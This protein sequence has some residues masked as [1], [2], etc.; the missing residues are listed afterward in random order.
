T[1]DEHPTT[2]DA[3]ADEP[4]GGVP[5]ARDV[6]P[7]APGGG[8]GANYGPPPAPV[9]PPGLPPVVDGG[10][11]AGTVAPLAPVRPVPKRRSRVRWVVWAVV[12]VLVLAGVISSQINLDYYAIQPGTAQSVQPFITVPPGKAHR[13][14]KPV[15]LTDVRE[16]RVTALTYL[17]FKLQSNTS[18][19]PL[20]DVTGGTAP[21]ELNA[22][23][24]LQMSQAEASAKTAAL[25]HLGY[26]VTA[27][28]VG[29]VIAGTF[30]GTPAYGVLN[31]GD[32]VTA[33]DG[34]PTP[35]ALALTQALAPH[36]SGQTVT[37]T[38]RKG[39]TAAPG[40]VPLTL[41]RTTVQIGG[42]T[43]TLDVGIMPQDQV[44]YTYPFPISIAVTNIGGPS[45]GLAM[46]LGVIDTLSG[47]RLT[48]G[49]TV[50]ATGTMDPDG[51]VGDV[52]GVAQKTV[53]VEDAGATIFLVPPGEYADA[54]SK[55]RP[56]LKIYP[57]STLDQAL[58]VLA[59]NGG[60]VP[61][62]ALVAATSDAAG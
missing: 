37:F 13:V 16:A 54:R 52:G 55:L 42:R 7:P 18:L 38:V 50:A 28:P 32:V 60:H 57:V 33:L 4:G 26:P 44:A 6:V 49:H 47:G 27:T 20:P 58:R 25:R 61:T 39:G 51:Q 3:P 40:P 46:T 36:H 1:D 8:I 17:I 14:A 29:A 48:G 30:E 2:P 15:L 43:A 62:A 35:T 19:Y 34:K 53:A 45:A 23:G 12:G 5:P 21:S 56:G 59:A 31:V 24:D 41:K 10:F 22:Q 11:P 9:P